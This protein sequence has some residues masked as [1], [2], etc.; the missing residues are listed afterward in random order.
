MTRLG[1][2]AGLLLLG[3]AAGCA[4]ERIPPPSAPR[5]VLER[6]AEAI[7]ADLDL[8]IRIDFAR[9]KSALGEEMLRA[10]AAQSPRAGDAAS[11]KLLVDAIARA[12]TVWVALRPAE[13]LEASDNV[14]VLRGRFAD[15]DPLKYGGEPR[16]RGPV[17]LG[18]AVRRY[19]RTAPPLRSAP[20][21][22]YVRLPDLMVFASAAEIDSVERVIE[23]GADD[24]RLDPPE[25]GALALE[26]RIGRLSESIAE[27]SPAAARLLARARRL[28]AHVDLEGGG[29]Q[30]ELE[31]EFELE[32]QARRAADATAL[33]ARALAETGGTASRIVAALRVEAVGSNLVIGVG[34]GAEQLAELVACARGDRECA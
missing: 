31:V 23:H 26:G 17:D 10:L 28:R 25:K 27:R 6:P 11:E 12:D 30:G 29:V 33:F 14:I 16:W 3:A 22:I 5:P 18:A 19:E 1:L 8:V 2:F 9:V 21:R 13:D 34:L 15:I 20:A 24:P 7:P 32:E 4:P